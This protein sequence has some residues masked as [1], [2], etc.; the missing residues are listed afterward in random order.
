MF[1]DSVL[2]VVQV[3]YLGEVKHQSWGTESYNEKYLI[4]YIMIYIQSV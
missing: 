2:K 4:K 3:N 1:P